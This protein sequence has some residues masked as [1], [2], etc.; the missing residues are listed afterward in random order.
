MKDY[1]GV[2]DAIEKDIIQLILL[3]ESFVTNWLQICRKTQKMVT[4]LFNLISSRRCSEGAGGATPVSIEKYCEAEGGG[5]GQGF[6][7]HLDIHQNLGFSFLLVLILSIVC[8]RDIGIRKCFSA[9]FC[10]L[11]RRKSVPRFAKYVHRFWM[12]SEDRG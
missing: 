12:P 1:E 11:S 4:K 6:S 10:C 7:Q 3:L 2:Y 9:T 5:R 8:Y